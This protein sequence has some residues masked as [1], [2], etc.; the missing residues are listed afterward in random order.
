MSDTLNYWLGKLARLQLY[1][2]GTKPLYVATPNGEV[3]TVHS[4]LE[5]KDR[6]TIIVD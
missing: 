4:L 5:E 6:V 2:H 1:G 3:Y